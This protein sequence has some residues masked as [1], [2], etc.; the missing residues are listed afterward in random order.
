M[1]YFISN[2]LFVSFFISFISYSLSNSSFFVLLNIFLKLFSSPLNS[3]I[4]IYFFE[5]AEE[6][7][8]KGIFVIFEK[9]TVCFDLVTK[10]LYLFASDLAELYSA[11]LRS[12]LT[13]LDKDSSVPEGKLHFF[14]KIR[15]LEL[16]FAFL[17]FS[18]E[19]L[20]FFLSYNK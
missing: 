19:G 6:Y 15:S 20:A 4:I 16:Y 12:I 13:W 1:V 11:E 8:Q 14:L 7:F 5:G 9:L 2:F 18:L 10:S 3:S 17:F